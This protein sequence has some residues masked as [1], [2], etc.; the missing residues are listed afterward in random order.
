[1]LTVAARTQ[2]CHN[3]PGGTGIITFSG[4]DGKLLAV[5]SAQTEER[6]WVGADSAAKSAPTALEPLSIEYTHKSQALAQQLKTPKRLN[7]AVVEENVSTIAKVASAG[8][9]FEASIA[10]MLMASPIMASTRVFDFV[11]KP[12][13]YP[14]AEHDLSVL[15]DH[16][17]TPYAAL[18]GN[19]SAL[20]AEWEKLC[21]LV[22][23]ETVLNALPLEE[24]WSRAFLH[25]KFNHFDILLLAALVQAAA[26]DVVLADR[27][28]PRLLGSLRREH[29]AYKAR[30][31]QMAHGS[32]SRRSR[33]ASDPR[34]R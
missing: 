30:A 20:C 17:K 10:S 18:G 32:L 24:L 1:M 6:Y 2:D 21:S 25:F 23:R 9:G 3:P 19:P 27:G 34:K 22:A 29:A 13:R 14:V 33:L 15:L 26:M 8:C 7:F 11:R 16:F 31:I 4:K 5:G 28:A 12:T